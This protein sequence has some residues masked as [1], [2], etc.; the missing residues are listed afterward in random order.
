PLSGKWQGT[1]GTLHAGGDFS[2]VFLIPVPL[3]C[4]RETAPGCFYLERGAEGKPTGQFL[5]LQAEEYT[6][7]GAGL[8]KLMVVFFNNQAGAPARVEAARAGGRTCS[9]PTRA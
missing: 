6:G 1:K 9:F 7:A 2:G 3:G 5:P 4:S 8:V